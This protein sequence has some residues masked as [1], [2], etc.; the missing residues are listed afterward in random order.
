MGKK[1]GKKRGKQSVSPAPTDGNADAASTTT[2][3]QADDSTKSSTD[4]SPPVQTE[5]DRA[6]QVCSIYELW[7]K[8][9]ENMPAKEAAEDYRRQIAAMEAMRDE[10]RQKREEV[11]RVRINNELHIQ[12]LT[13]SVYSH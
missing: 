3:P 9:S 1:A 6:L 5:A 10:I 13:F 12:V 7:T 8:L 11:E 4:E 2:P